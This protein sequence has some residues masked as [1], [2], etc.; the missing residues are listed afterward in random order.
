MLHDRFG[1]FVVIRKGV[2]VRAMAA[3]GK[4]RRWVGF[5]PFLVAA[6]LAACAEALGD[7]PGGNGDHGNGRHGDHTHREKSNGVSLML[8]PSLQSAKGR[9]RSG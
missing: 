8:H 5:L 7:A 9:T 6:A 3:A 2:E 4:N 1:D